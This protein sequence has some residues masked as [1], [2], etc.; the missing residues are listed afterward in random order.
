MS[1]MNKVLT[2]T[3]LVHNWVYMNN[4]F[5]PATAIFG[6]YEGRG[7]RLARHPQLEPMGLAYLYSWAHQNSIDLRKTLRCWRYVTGSRKLSA[8]EQ[9]TADSIIHMINNLPANI[10]NHIRSQL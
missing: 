10:Q 7:D 9:I 6:E 1:F 5:W 2:N 3:A 8:S 4:S